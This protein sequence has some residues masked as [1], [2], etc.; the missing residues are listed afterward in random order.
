[1]KT[2]ITSALYVFL[3]GNIIKKVF[4]CSLGFCQFTLTQKRFMKSTVIILQVKKLLN[5]YCWEK[6]THF[7][8][9]IQLLYIVIKVPIIFLLI[10]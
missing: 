8:R 4:L 7:Y 3:Q 9:I 6:K 2:L 1:M 10:G 5:K